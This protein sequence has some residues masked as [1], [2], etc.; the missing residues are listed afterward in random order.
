MVT[1]ASA[2]VTATVSGSGPALWIFH[3][4]LAD[5]GSCIPLAQALSDRFTVTLP[6][7][8]GF[9]GSS[10]TTPQLRAIADRMA[11]AIAGQPVTII[12]NGYGSFVALEL[13]LRHPAL[14][15]RLAL[16]GTG[17]AFSEPGRQAFR[18]MAAAVTGKGLA[19][20]ADVAMRRLFAPAFQAAHPAL[21]AE[22]RAAFLNTDPAVF[23][24]ACAELAALDLRAQVASLDIP[25][26]ALA[27]DARLGG[28]PDRRTVCAAGPK[29]LRGAGG[30]RGVPGRR[31]RGGG[32][33]CRA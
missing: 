13:A 21:M 10:A 29:R 1:F 23:T 14:V 31:A 19:A 24:G 27:G 18:N 28:R 11:E 26:L 16:A 8:P 33:G 20:I 2:T 12:G 30:V 7:L 22:R 17:A 3:S 4:L 5:A 32:Y 9:A 15:R 6:N 25:L